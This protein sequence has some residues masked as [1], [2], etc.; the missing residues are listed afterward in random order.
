MTPSNPA[1]LNPMAAQP[2]KSIPVLESAAVAPITLRVGEYSG[3]HERSDAAENRRR[4]LTVADQ[5]FAERG[6][7]NVNM[8][9][10][11]KAAGVG[12]GTLYRR[13]ANKG[14]LCMAL[15]DSQMVDFQN[16]VLAHLRAQS[17]QQSPRLTQ[18]EWFLDALVYFNERHAPLLCAAQHEGIAGAIGAALPTSSPF[19]WM[20]MTVIGLMQ[21]GIRTREFDASLDVPMIA[22]A[23]LGILQPQVFQALRLTDAG[24]SLERISAGIIRL[25]RGLAEE[26]A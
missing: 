3:R 17:T 11:A 19:A 12:Q 25:L 7:V 18:L 24:Y 26:S 8:Q 23:L 6:V 13:Y 16:T 22:D 20:R 21:S 2:S 14:A 15:L 1:K 10:V 4:I 5:L 9:D